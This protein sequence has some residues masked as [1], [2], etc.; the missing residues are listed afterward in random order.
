MTYDE[1]IRTINDYLRNPRKSQIVFGPRLQ[2]FM[3]VFSKIQVNVRKLQHD[4][5][6]PADEYPVKEVQETLGIA[7]HIIV[8]EMMSDD[9]TL[10]FSAW[11]TLLMN[12]NNNT[13]KD[14]EMHREIVFCER[15]NDGLMSM[16]DTIN[17]LKVL[18]DRLKQLKY[19]SPPAFEISKHFLKH[20]D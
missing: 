4:E 11:L 10:F 9:L 17:T 18:N 1:C 2:K 14:A 6:V 19:W 13:V 7:K 16:R 3:E 12:W 8:Q 5:T 15:L 20:L